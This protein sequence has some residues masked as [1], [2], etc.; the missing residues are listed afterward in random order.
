ME[1]GPGGATNSMCP[2]AGAL[3]TKSTPMLPF[4]PGRL[5]TT[6]A[7]PKFLLKSSAST[8]A[9]RSTDPPGG[10]VAMRRTVWLARGCCAE[11]ASGRAHAAAS[12]MVRSADFIEGDYVTARASTSAVS[13]NTYSLRGREE[14]GNELRGQ[15]LAAVHGKPGI[16]PVVL[17]SGVDGDVLVAEVRQAV[18]G[19]MRILAAAARAVDDDL[20]GLVREHLGRKRV[21]PVLRQGPRA[22]P[23]PVAPVPFPQGLDE[24]P[25]GD[26]GGGSAPPFAVSF[27]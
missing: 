7:T 11:A 25:R 18:R 5:S 1:T 23:G 21:H 2:S 27:V 16:H 17:A 26:G 13:R 6:K 9:S 22:R 3:T 4:A 12:A 8:R 15:R 20:G 10:L 14:R 19:D 24:H